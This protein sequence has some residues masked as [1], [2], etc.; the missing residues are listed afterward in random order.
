MSELDQS[1]ATP[2]DET[3]APSAAGTHPPVEET[4]ASPIDDAVQT[5]VKYSM[6]NPE[7]KA[8]R[9]II[10]DDLE[11]SLRIVPALTDLALNSLV[12]S[13]DT[14]P[15]YDQL[16][17]KHREQLLKTLPTHVP[18]KVT[19]PLIDDEKY[20][21]KCCKEKWPI[22][23]IKQYD[24]SWKRFYF[25]K[26]IEE[27][28]ENVVPGKDDFKALFEYVD[29]GKVF[30]RMNSEEFQTLFSGARYV[31]RIDVRQLLPPVETQDRIVQNEDDLNDEDED[32]ELH[33]EQDA[34]KKKTLS[35]HFDFTD[36]IKRLPNLEEL[37]LVYG[38]K[39][40]GMNFE[41]TMFEFT[42]KD[43]QI[44][45]KCVQQCR[46]L[47]VLHLHRSK[48]DNQKVRML[49]RDGLLDHPTLEELN[50]EH[51]LI[52]EGNHSSLSSI[53]RSSSFVV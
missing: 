27:I 35:D 8:V 5:E 16:L 32:G 6:V 31:K 51:N 29:L 13:F 3:A 33:D 25:E 1:T 43:C 9:R 20:W 14:T 7:L 50:L 15:K 34:E 42:K 47:K 17:D 40:C 46:T 11:W 48:I 38:V 24:N 12:Q 2:A 53:N 39:G 22:C 23:D 4:T 18:L 30:N 37:H 52:S 19:A 41:W 28:I 36:L 26:N 44:L 45:A 49:I 10:A 21:E